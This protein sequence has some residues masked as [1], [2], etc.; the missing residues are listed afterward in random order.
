[1]NSRFFVTCPKGLESLLA[2]ELAG[3]QLAVTRETPAGIWVEGEQRDAYL[4]CLHSRLANR[5]IWHLG[6]FEVDSAES[7]HRAVTSLDWSQHLAS[8]GRF[9]VSFQGLGAGIRN[10]Q[11]GVQCVKD[12][13]VDRLRAPDG[14][15]PSVDRQ[16]PD[17]SVHVRLHRDRI[18]VGIDLAGES[19][20]RR[21]YRPESGAA[22]LKENLAA[23]LL[24]R[25]GWPAIAAAGSDF[26][27]PLCGSGTLLIEAALIATDTA[28]G[29]LRESFALERW[30]LH[31]A[32]LWE[33]LR[34]EAQARSV[35]GQAGSAS[36]YYGFDQDKRII[37]TARRNIER[38][39]FAD[40]I[41]VEARDLADLSAPVQT[42]PGLILTNP[43]Y[44]ERLSEREELGAL[45]LT[46][47]ERVR[48]AFSGWQ[49][50]VF[51]GVP[52]F[53]HALGLR[54]SRRYNLY[55][56][57]LPAKL[58]LFKVEKEQEARAR[59]PEDPKAPPRPRIVN[60]ERAEMLANRL[61]KN[62]KSLGS[63]ARKQQL[64]CYRL[65][66]ADMPEYAFAID[67]YGD[68]LHVQEY[69]AP[70]SVDETAARERLAEATA[71]IPEAL[72]VNPQK[73]IVKQRRRQRGDEQYERQGERG[74]RITVSEGPCRFYVNLTDYLDTG[75]F[76]DHRPARTWLRQQAAGKSVLNLFCYTATATVHAALGG[77]RRSLS[78][79]LSKTYLAWARDNF[80]LNDI[81]LNDHRLE[82]ADCLQ[83]LAQPARETFDLIFLDPPTFS[84]SARME[85]VLDVQRDQEALIDG[86]MAR[87]APTGTLL[88]S[89][90]FRRFQLSSDIESRYQVQ[91]ISRATIDRDFSRNAKIHRTWLIRHQNS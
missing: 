72:G 58:L 85:D 46:L 83:W 77:A 5:V 18:H 34:A 22:P 54:T 1:M 63:W 12:G 26:V 23:A 73:V 43:P 2:Q 6:D 39:G 15:R 21:G 66:D 32:A 33:N 89:N 20:H 45:Y 35:A 65:Y 57:S 11:F 55:N 90:N 76:L 30:P 56:G 75:L 50:G 29:L 87:L 84:N 49:L 14:T 52:E 28:P 27:D 59:T 60:R 51:T 24:I 16:D 38:A 82:Q 79:D 25:A 91:D 64:E 78:V 70:K 81:D 53:G 86:A 31:D 47:G 80:T 36:R 13:I 4:A 19:L 44:G 7:I 71:V 10:T 62:L 88:F 8:N 68:W 42:T 48:Q 61:R 3:L 69:M 40:R 74:Q 37:S 17:L 41:Q 67:V 9:R